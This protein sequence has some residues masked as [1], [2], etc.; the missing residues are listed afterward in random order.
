MARDARFELT[1]FGSGGRRSIQLSY[2]RVRVAQHTG[3]AGERPCACQW[4]R[5]S[6]IMP[7]FSR[8]LHPGFSLVS[9]ADD[10]FARQFGI[11]IACLVVFMFI[12]IFLA[13]TIAGTSTEARHQSA[14]EAL[15]RVVPV[16]Q[17]RLA[18]EAVPAAA[19]AAPATA[20]PAAAADGTAVY[21]SVC[22]ACHVAGVAGAP[23]VGDAAAWQPRLGQGLDGLVAS[24]VHGK[25]AMPPRGG[26]PKL[27]D[28]EIRAAVEH[29]LKE[30]GVS[31]N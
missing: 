5:H 16:G 23:K 1:T 20:A 8:R 10:V 6:A 28:A 12:A 13:R 9:K 4:A 29:M 30:T 25:N 14:K 11:V 7:G 26:N 31:A 15:A 21:N 2:G 18:G 3:N 24:V 19:P 17:V 22:M 27:S